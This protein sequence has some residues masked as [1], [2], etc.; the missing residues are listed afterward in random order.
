MRT[1]PD[2]FHRKTKTAQ[3]KSELLKKHPL[4]FQHTQQKKAALFGIYHNIFR[5]EK[6]F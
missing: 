3:K 2:K 4:T 1:S 6:I 5:F